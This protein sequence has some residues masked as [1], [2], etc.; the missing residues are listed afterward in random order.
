MTVTISTVKTSVRSHEILISSM[1]ACVSVVNLR[2]H[3]TTHADAVCNFEMVGKSVF[4][5]SRLVC[6]LPPPSPD[7]PGQVL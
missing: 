6:F 5:D 3:L 7:L 2:R 4:A 1:D